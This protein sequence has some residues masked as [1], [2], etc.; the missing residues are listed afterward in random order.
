[1]IP[2]VFNITNLFSFIAFFI[3]GTRWQTLMLVWEETEKIAPPRSQFDKHKLA[4]QMKMITIVILTVSLSKCLSLF[5][6][7]N[8][9]MVMYLLH[10]IL[11]ELLKGFM[12]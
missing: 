10:T 3:L 2:L 12:T 5:V 11:C 8:M 1:M 7:S 9:L 4:Y 6:M